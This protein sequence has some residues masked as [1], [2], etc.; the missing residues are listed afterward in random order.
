[1]EEVKKRKAE[2]ELEGYRRKVRV[3]QQEEKESLENFRCQ[4]IFLPGLV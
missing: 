1:M 2:K 3:K 4:S